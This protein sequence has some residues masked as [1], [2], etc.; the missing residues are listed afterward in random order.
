MRNK[1]VLFLIGVVMTILSCIASI[2]NI[3]PNTS[4]IK[5]I[6]EKYVLGKL[7]VNLLKIF[8]LLLYVYTLKVLIKT[9]NFNK[10]ELA[11][12]ILLA[13]IIDLLLSGDNLFLLISTIYCFIITYMFSKNRR[14][15]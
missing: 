10:I 13:H 3:G 9:S 8:A 12:P 5:N 7:L 1:K 4:I 2:N 11:P 6:E 15:A 14:L